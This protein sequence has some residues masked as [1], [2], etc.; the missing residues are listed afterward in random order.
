MT[1]RV[2]AMN[3]R[4]VHDVIRMAAPPPLSSPLLFAI[5]TA[6]SPA[7]ALTSATCLEQALLIHQNTPDPPEKLALVP[8]LHLEDLSPDALIVP[9]EVT[10]HGSTTVVQHEQPTQAIMH[11]SLGFN[12]AAVDNL[13]ML[14]LFLRA[15]RTLPTTRRSD[16]AM[17]R[18]I[19]THTGGIGFTTSLTPRW[20]AHDEVIGHAFVQGKAL[21]DK[22]GLGCRVH[23]IR[24]RPDV[25]GW[26]VVGALVWCRARRT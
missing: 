9:R 21:S 15:L 24:V 8:T 16:V 17:A 6:A 13:T 4:Y 10:H 20:R 11:L 5:A 23:H 3:K 26:L 19:D 22:V 2:C 14:P 1:W 18:A 12:L 7:F 25:L